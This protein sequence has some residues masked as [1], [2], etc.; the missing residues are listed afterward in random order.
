MVGTL[1]EQGDAVV[2]AGGDAVVGAGGA[3]VG[4]GGAGV[5][6]PP[7]PLMVMSEHALKCSCAIG[8]TPTPQSL[9]PGMHA[10]VLP[11][12]YVH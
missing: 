3:D 8:F 9:V 4:P 5:G 11:A 10:Q 12:I 2:G 7:L 6:L 1:S